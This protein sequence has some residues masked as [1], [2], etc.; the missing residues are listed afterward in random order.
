MLY[1]DI[2]LMLNWSVI[3]LRQGGSYVSSNREL[4]MFFNYARKPALAA[5]HT[6]IVDVASYNLVLSTSAAMWSW[7]YNLQ[8]FCVTKLGFFLVFDLDSRRNNFDLIL[9]TFL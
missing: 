1:D 5:D 6:P 3:S 9:R 2:F 8:L 7:F 4:K